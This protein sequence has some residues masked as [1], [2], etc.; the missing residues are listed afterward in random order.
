M[1]VAAHPL[2]RIPHDME[3]AVV[4]LLCLRGKAQQS[5]L[6][7]SHPLLG[8]V[9]PDDHTIT[10]HAQGTLE[11]LIQPEHLPGLFHREEPPD[12]AGGL[13]GLA[14]F[15]VGIAA[16]DRAQRVGT[17]VPDGSPV[18]GDGIADTGQLGHQRRQVG[19]GT[20]C[21]GQHHN[22]P[23]RGL[24]NGLPGTGRDGIF[25]AQQGAV[26][27]QGSNT[28]LWHKRSFEK[29]LRCDFYFVPIL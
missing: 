26:Q 2:R 3:S 16:V 23:G 27:I 14:R 11:F 28:D 29:I 6:T 5:A 8:Q 22:A 1:G 25:M 13:A 9:V 15:R 21:G 10:E 18:G 17:Q 7:L 19:Q 12:K 4:G 20:S 24:C